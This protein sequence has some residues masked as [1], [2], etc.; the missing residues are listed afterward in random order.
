MMR[1]CWQTL[2]DASRALATD[3]ALDRRAQLDN[4]SNAEQIE[5][6]VSLI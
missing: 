5:F 1:E 2:F 6:F 3:D 4:G